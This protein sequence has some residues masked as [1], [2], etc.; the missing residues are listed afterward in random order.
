M[1]DVINKA[2]AAVNVGTGAIIS[3]LASSGDMENLTS[4]PLTQNGGVLLPEQS[5]RFLD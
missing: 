5:R 2:A 4:N 3:D 1:S